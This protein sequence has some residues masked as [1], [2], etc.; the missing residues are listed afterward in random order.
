MFQGNLGSTGFKTSLY[1]IHEKL[2]EKK[3]NYI[4]IT[5]SSKN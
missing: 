1:Y 2:P 5:I 3:T 4:I